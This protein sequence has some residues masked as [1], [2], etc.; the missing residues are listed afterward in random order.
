MSTIILCIFRHPL[1]LTPFIGNIFLSL[2]EC[3]GTLDGNQLIL[4]FVCL[5]WFGLV[6]FVFVLFCFVLIKG[7]A[8]IAPRGGSPSVPKLSRLP[9]ETCPLVPRQATAAQ[10]HAEGRLERR[11]ERTPDSSFLHVANT[12]GHGR[13]PMPGPCRPTESRVSHFI[14]KTLRTRPK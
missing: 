4:F 1:V 6:P 10:P 13:H 7:P 11:A 8:E 5:F 14:L 2:S 9:A 3:P 12:H